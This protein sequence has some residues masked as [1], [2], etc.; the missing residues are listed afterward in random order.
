[1]ADRL[2]PALPSRYRLIREIGRGGTACV[3]LA[4]E[5]HPEREVAIK[6][7]EPEITA[8]V[9]SERFL[10]EVDFAS[11][12]SHPHI[13]PI[14]AAG[15]ADGLLYYVMPYVAGDTLRDRLA[16]ERVL[17]LDD[18]LRIVLDVADA[19]SYAHG[20]NV[21]HRDIKPDNILLQAGHA[22]VA[23]FGIARAITATGKGPLTGA[24]FI[25]GTPA[26]MS[27][28]QAS[29][30]E[31]IDG[32]TDIY[33]LGCVLYE[34]LTGETPHTGA[35]PD[36]VIAKKLYSPVPR[37]AVLRPTVPESLETVLAVALARTPADRY[38]TAAQFRE[39]LSAA[40]P[41]PSAASPAA[42][43]MRTSSPSPRAPGTWSP[44]A[45]PPAVRPDAWMLSSRVGLTMVLA[46]VAVVN[47]VETTADNWIGARSVAV[48]EVRH[49]VAHAMQWFE[50]NVSFAGHDV[51]NVVALYGYATAYFFLFPALLVS[52]AVACARRP[53]LGPYRLLVTAI[54]IAYALSL[55]FYLLF[56]V[57]E[58]W[59]FAE[60]GAVLLSDR[61]SSHLIEFVRPMSGLDNCFPS[62]HVS[63]TVVAVLACFIYGLRFRWS[64]LAIGIGVILSTFVLGIHW[65]ADILGGV[66]AGLISITIALRLESRR[67]ILPS[68]AAASPA[69]ARLGG[70]GHDLAPTL[71]TPVR[72]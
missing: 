8:L 2:G 71:A 70:F 50:W 64:A 44:A 69:P 23:D 35:S 55:P 40:L 29:G 24:G 33:S 10:R 38:Q 5:S 12:L 61:W 25:V 36:A 27:P 67:G 57:P 28:E 60:S 21:I 16:R 4:Q 52:V 68:A 63:L 19:L 53:A 22:I 45:C 54:A 46:G 47:W 62:F 41:A 9:G 34:M 31:V 6:V 48:T 7:L 51:T 72:G 39:A 59:A 49:Q 18:A 65:V 43:F 11:K 17:P 3:F 26:Y 32:R 30:S 13:L 42:P 66:A 37:A 15:E 1:L 20:H 56:P 58:R 14:F